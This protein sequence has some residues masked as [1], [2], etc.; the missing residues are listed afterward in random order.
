MEVLLG[1]SMYIASSVFVRHSLRAL[2]TGLEVELQRV[3]VNAPASGASTQ[4]RGREKSLVI[5]M[6]VKGLTRVS[7]A[8][9]EWNM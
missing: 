6:K 5:G 2:Y 9:S 7:H 4:K 8:P 1:L 3:R